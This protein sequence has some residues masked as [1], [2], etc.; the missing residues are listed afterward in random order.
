MKVAIH[1]PNFLPWLGYFNKIKQ[2]DVFVFLDDVQ[3]ERGKTFTSRTKILINNNESWLTIPIKNKS[4]LR[5]INDIQVDSPLLWKKKQLKTIEM[6]Y[7][8]SPYFN[9]IFDLI[10]KIYSQDIQLLVD[11]NIPL[12]IEICKYL[13]IQ[14]KFIKSSNLIESKEKIGW[15]KILFILK[16]IKAEIYLSGSGEGSK[17]YVNEYDLLKNSIKLEWQTYVM[18]EYTRFNSAKTLSHLSIIDLLFYKGKDAIHYI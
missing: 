3:F 17:R 4:D 11:Y 6:N 18:K 7:K 8:K 2:V 9:E 1:Q 13:D 10:Q 15:D 16:E 14:T 5:N 12:I